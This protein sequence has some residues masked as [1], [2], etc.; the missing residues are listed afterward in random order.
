MSRKL[1]TYYTPEDTELLARALES[2]IIQCL[3]NA[4]LYPDKEN[5]WRQKA[6]DM[7][8]KFT[9]DFGRHYSYFINRSF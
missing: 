9:T 4:G 8:R 2:S 6:D 5:F 1:S 7:E 3:M